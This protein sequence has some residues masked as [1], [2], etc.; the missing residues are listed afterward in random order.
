MPRILSFVL[1]LLVLTTQASFDA[2]GATKGS[3]TK[4]LK[5]PPGN[6]IKYSEDPQCGS[7]GTVLLAKGLIRFDL[8]QSASCVEFCVDVP[9]GATVTKTRFWAANLGQ[10]VGDG[11]LPDAGGWKAC[12]SEPPDWI[13]LPIPAVTGGLFPVPTVSHIPV[14]GPTPGI[15]ANFGWARWEGTGPQCG[16]F[17]NWSHDTDRLARID[18]D[19]EK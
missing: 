12:G 2:H 1:V 6:Y 5:V 14:P 18:V 13:Q 17:K 7:V 9:A 19:Y 11:G 10:A 4:N 8:T 3:A 16:R 15:C